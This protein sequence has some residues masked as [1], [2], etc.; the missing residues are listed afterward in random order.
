MFRN[1]GVRK[2]NVDSNKDVGDN[3]KGSSKAI[4]ELYCFIYRRGIFH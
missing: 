4:E 2:T 3:S 1:K